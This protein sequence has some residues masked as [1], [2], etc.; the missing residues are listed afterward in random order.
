MTSIMPTPKLRRHGDLREEVGHILYLV[1]LSQ[2]IPN[3]CSIAERLVAEDL[4]AIEDLTVI[5]RTIPGLGFKDINERTSSGS[6]TGVY[7][8]PDRPIFRGIQYVG[9]HLHMN[10]IE[11]LSRTIVTDSCYHLEN[12]LK[13]RLS[14]SE[15]QHWSVGVILNTTQGK[16]LNGSLRK[17]L[18]V[19]NRAVYNRAKH[20]IEMIDFDS[21]MFSAADAIAIYLCCRAMGAKLIGKLALKTKYGT[22]IFPEMEPDAET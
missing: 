7:Q 19:L 20:T 16:R 4:S 1:G 17:A 12:S 6:L 22:L 2:H 3:I 11:W 10:N 13:R 14:I 5:D 21:H 9:M 8:I 15:D 18:I